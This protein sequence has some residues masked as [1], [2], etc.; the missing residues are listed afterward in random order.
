[1]TASTTNIWTLLDERVAKL[2]IDLGVTEEK[3]T[4]VFGHLYH[5]SLCRSHNGAAVDAYNLLPAACCDLL[6]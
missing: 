1:M 3:I 6:R 4:E 5:G 2:A